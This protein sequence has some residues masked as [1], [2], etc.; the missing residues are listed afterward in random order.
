MLLFAN[1]FRIQRSIYCAAFQ[2]RLKKKHIRIKFLM[3][4]VNF[5]IN[6]HDDRSFVDISTETSLF[7]F[8]IARVA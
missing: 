5:T 2:G 1:P 6:T 7:L 4:V 8:I 3:S